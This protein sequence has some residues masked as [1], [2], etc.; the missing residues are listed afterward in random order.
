LDRE[1]KHRLA[2]IRHLEEVKGNAALTCWYN[3]NVREVDVA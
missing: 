3:N 2:I 1:A